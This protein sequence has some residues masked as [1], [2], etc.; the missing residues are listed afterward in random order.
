[1]ERGRGWENESKAE[2]FMI[3]L[4][5]YIVSLLCLPV[6]EMQKMQVWSLGWE[7][8]LEEEMATHSSILAWKNSMDRGAWWATVHGFAKSWTRLSTQHDFLPYSVGWHSRDL[9]SLTQKRDSHIVKK[10]YE[11]G[12]ES[13]SCSVVSNSLGPYGLYSLW[14]SPDQSTGVGSLSLLQ[15]IFP[16]WGSNPGPP[17]CRW[18]LYQ[19]SHKGSPRIL[20]WVAY[21]FS[22]GFSQPRI[23]TGISCIVGRFFTNW[24]MRKAH[25]V[26]YIYANI[27]VRWDIYWQIY[28]AWEGIY[29]S[30]F[31]CCTKANRKKS[32]DL[33]SIF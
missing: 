25:E 23:Q 14:N 20:E 33:G 1:M 24:A 9:P 30:S 29:E 11:V 2:T 28:C 12:C 3:Y 21:P 8:A 26:G 6:K 5:T 18:I 10:L 17:H 13:E 15:G 31:L 4:G 32:G 27:H 22:R 19:L 7:D 16:T